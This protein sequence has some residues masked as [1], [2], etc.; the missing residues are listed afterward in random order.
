MKSPRAD[1]KDC[2]LPTAQTAMIAIST[3][4]MR[5]TAERSVVRR[6][7]IMPTAQPTTN[8]T[9]ALSDLIAECTAPVAA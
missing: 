9:S 3:P 7:S 1:K 4:S 6:L 2:M 5:L 8:P